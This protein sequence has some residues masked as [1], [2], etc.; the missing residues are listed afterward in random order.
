[1]DTGGAARPGAGA[2]AGAARPGRRADLLA[3]CGGRLSSA[4]ILPVAGLLVPRRPGPC[5]HEQRGSGGL[6]DPGGGVGLLLVERLVLEQ[7]GDDPVERLPVLT[8][9]PPRL[10]VALQDEGAHLLVH[11]GEELVGGTGVP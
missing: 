10:V 5:P 2:V 8:E 4:G 7:G 6:G 9:Q 1:R 3:V 11:C